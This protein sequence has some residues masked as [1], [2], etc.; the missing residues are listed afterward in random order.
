MNFKIR[1]FPHD[2]KYSLNEGCFYGM[3]L[4]RG[5]SSAWKIQLRLDPQKHV[6]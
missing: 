3:K 2:K 6:Y 5:R 4:K 1:E